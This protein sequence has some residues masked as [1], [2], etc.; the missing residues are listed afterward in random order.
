MRSGL[1]PWHAGASTA[2]SLH[3]PQC[4]TETR[5]F[6]IS[7]APHGTSACS[8]LIWLVFRPRDLRAPATRRI[9]P[10]QIFQ[11]A[12]ETRSRRLLACC[13]PDLPG[14]RCFRSETTLPDS[15]CIGTLPSRPSS[16][17]DWPYIA[18]IA[19]KASKQLMPP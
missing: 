16:A 12:G 18:I 15:A 2:Q 14:T 5:G 4:S 1:L 8:S 19:R 13:V 11:D 17:Q 10:L 9:S 7:K 3:F 6:R